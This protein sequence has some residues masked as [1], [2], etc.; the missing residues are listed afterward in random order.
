[1]HYFLTVK[2]I[3][4]LQ[5]FDDITRYEALGQNAKMLQSLGKRAI[6][7]VSE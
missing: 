3:K 7:D 1:M 5:N 4:P 2:V 6:L